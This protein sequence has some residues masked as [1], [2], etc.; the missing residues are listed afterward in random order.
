M[1]DKDRTRIAALLGRPHMTKAILA[2]NASVHRNTL[3]GVEEEG[4]NPRAKTLDRIMAAVERLE[5]AYP[6]KGKT[7]EERQEAHS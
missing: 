2:S 7:D 3:N 4:W 5:K 6:P 1:L